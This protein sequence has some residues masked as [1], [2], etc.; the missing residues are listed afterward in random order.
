MT[1]DLPS[2]P[3]FGQNGIFSTFRIPDQKRSRIRGVSQRPRQGQSSARTARQQSLRAMEQWQSHRVE[4]GPAPHR[5]CPITNFRISTTELIETLAVVRRCFA[6]MP[7]NNDRRNPQRDTRQICIGKQ[8]VARAGRKSV[9]KAG[10]ARLV[11][12]DADRTRTR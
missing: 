9:R 12:E 1:Y 8:I 11:L 3:Q 2:P 4:A 5:V 6:C 7:M 10:S